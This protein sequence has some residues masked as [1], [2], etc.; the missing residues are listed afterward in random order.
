MDDVSGTNN[1]MNLFTNKFKN[2][3]N[4]VG[5]DLNELETL[6]SNTNEALEVNVSHHM[7]RSDYK[8]LISHMVPL[9]LSPGTYYYDNFDFVLSLLAFT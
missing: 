7:V 5:Y 4:S 8:Y 1:V 3:Y 2:L 9:K 6:V